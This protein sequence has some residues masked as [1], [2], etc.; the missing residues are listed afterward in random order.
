MRIVLLGLPG[1][2]KGTQAKRISQRYKIPHISTGDIFRENIENNTTLGQEAKKYTNK[3]ELVPDQLVIEM[4]DERLHHDDV[5][6]V[7]Y[8]YLLDGFPRTVAQAEALETLNIKNKSELDYVVDLEVPFDILVSRVSGRRVCP[9]CKATYHITHNKPIKEG[10]CD[11]DGTPL[12]HREDDQ[13]ET[14]KKRIAVFKKRTEPLIEYYK[15]LGKLVSIN[16]LQHID[17]VFADILKAIDKE[18]QE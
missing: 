17:D 11:Y 14:V 12:I 3:G 13:E 2:G 6:S 1:C 9:Q 4:M 16:G 15:K 5:Q 8:G 7:G 10:V 18:G